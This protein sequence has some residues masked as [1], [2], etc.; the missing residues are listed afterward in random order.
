MAGPLYCDLIERA[1]AGVGMQPAF[2]AR[3]I[4][5]E[6]RFDRLAVSRAGAQGIAQFMPGTAAERGLEDPWDPRQAIP[7]AASFL[8]DLKQKFGNY[9]LAA[10]AYNA[11]PNRVAA[12]LDGRARL[13]GETEDYVAAVALAPADV[14]RDPARQVGRRPLAPGLAFGE[15]CRG[16]PT[17]ASRAMG[18]V[19]GR[20]WGGQIAAGITRTAALRAFYRARGQVAHLIG[21]REPIIVRSRLVGGRRL[22]SARVGAASRAAARS[23]CNKVKSAGVACLVRRN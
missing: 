11:G 23:L 15:A 13:P 18:V 19:E 21:D 10:A 20:A 3:V 1:A 17:I 9:G 8:S 14:F 12:W 7:A 4:W 2:L 5:R 16:L 22:Y 6:S